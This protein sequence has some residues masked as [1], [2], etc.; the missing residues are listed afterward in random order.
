MPMWHG[1]PWLARA[2]LAAAAAAVLAAAGCS[3]V[4]NPVGTAPTSSASAHPSASTSASVSSDRP[5]AP[6]TGLP[7]SSTTDA[8]RPAV[9]L[10]VS[11][12]DPEGLNTAD[13]VF[14]E[15]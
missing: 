2:G 13:V 3:Q 8:D 12:T 1:S 5:V 6:L 14:E 15:M 11:G 7:V 4:P 9:V 10:D